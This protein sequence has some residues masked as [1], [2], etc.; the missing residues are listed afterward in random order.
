MASALDL[1]DLEAAKKRAQ[2][3][4]AQ[5]SKAHE[6]VVPVSQALS[7]R[8]RIIPQNYADRY[9]GGDPGAYGRELANLP[10][11]Q[12]TAVAPQTGPGGAVALGEAQNYTSAQAERFKQMMA[13]RSG[14]NQTRMSGLANAMAARLAQDSTN[15]GQTN[16]L[17]L[18][19]ENANV[20]NTELARLRAK[21][22]QDNNAY[23]QF[24][25]RDLQAQ[26]DALAALGSGGGSGGGSGSGS[27]TPTGFVLPTLPGSASQTTT[28]FVIPAF[29]TKAPATPAEKFN[30]K[31][32]SKAATKYAS[33]RAATLVPKSKKPLAPGMKK[34]GL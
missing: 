32:G 34:I 12:N 15:R 28:P 2:E 3:L 10:A 8:A 26:A 7:E 30:E 24:Y 22:A 4:A 18:L 19:Q 13:A 9:Q 23:Q 5:S 14:A 11:W 31:Y 25:Q 1:L 6:P 17:R 21:Q 33:S 20:N 27:G 16:D 29:G